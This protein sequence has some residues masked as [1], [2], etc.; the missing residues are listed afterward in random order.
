VRATF[1]Q[2]GSVTDHARIPPFAID[3]KIAYYGAESRHAGDLIVDVLGKSGLLSS[4]LMSGRMMDDYS[5]GS[6][7]LKS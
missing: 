1:R 4:H 6:S 5:V 3:V 2:G 7:V